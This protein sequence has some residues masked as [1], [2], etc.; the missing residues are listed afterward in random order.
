MQ[1][2]YFTLKNISE[3]EDSD[4]SHSFGEAKSL[5]IVG[6]GKNLQVQFCEFHIFF[7]LDHMEAQTIRCVVPL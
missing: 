1:S 2:V 7:W 4:V 3:K 5:L 6:K